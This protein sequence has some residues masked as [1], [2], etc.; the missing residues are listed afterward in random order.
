MK[1]KFISGD[2]VRRISGGPDMTVRGIHFDVL[3]NTYKEDM[4]DCIWFEESTDGKKE[5]HYCPFH[6]NEL[7]KVAQVSSDA[8][9]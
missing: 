8:K 6:V 9:S 5:V 1:P 2:R 7:I 3:A 4:Y